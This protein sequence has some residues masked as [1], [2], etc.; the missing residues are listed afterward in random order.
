MKIVTCYTPGALR[1]ET[2]F[3]I[4][5]AIAMCPE[6]VVWDA[7]EIAP[8]DERAYGKIIAECWNSGDDLFIVEPDVEISSDTLFQMRACQYGYCGFSYSWGPEVGIALG[9]T[10]FRRSFM[11]KYPDAVQRAVAEGVSFRQFDVV[12]QRHILVGE[13]SQQP[14]AHG[15]VVHWNPAKQLLPYGRPEPI[16]VLPRW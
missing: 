11:E 6:S 13:Y 14:H 5:S 10:R 7:R 12:L 3:G 8:D 1:E 2:E 9:A 15:S 16:T 4:T